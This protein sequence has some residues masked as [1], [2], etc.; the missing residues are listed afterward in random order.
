[1]VAV[2]PAGSGW[3]YRFVRVYVGTA[4]HEFLNLTIHFQREG[5]VCVQNGSGFPIF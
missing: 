5:T 1:M 2:V 4:Y 3:W